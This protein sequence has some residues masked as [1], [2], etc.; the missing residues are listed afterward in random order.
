MRCGQILQWRLCNLPQRCACD[1]ASPA[2]SSTS[3]IC[4]SLAAK[5]TCCSGV[6][7][8]LRRTQKIYCKQHCCDFPPFFPGLDGIALATTPSTWLSVHCPALAVKCSNRSEYLEQ[9]TSYIK[10]WD[11]AEDGTNWCLVFILSSWTWRAVYRGAGR[12]FS[13]GVPIPRNRS[14]MWG[15]AAEKV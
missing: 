12:N 10:N 11:L 14:Q 9:S 6:F 2:K 5:Q 1:K 15:S 13:G 8:N 7:R 3:I 4:I